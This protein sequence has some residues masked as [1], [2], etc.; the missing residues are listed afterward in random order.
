M[1]EAHF[2]IALAVIAALIAYWYYIKQIGWD[3]G[4][5]A[6][7]WGL[8]TVLGWFIAILAAAIVTS[9]FAY[10]TGVNPLLG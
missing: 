4:F 5:F 1:N 10:I 6:K 9:L 3:Y 2:G 7:G 8:L